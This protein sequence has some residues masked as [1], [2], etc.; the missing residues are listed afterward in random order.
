[1]GQRA[2]AVSDTPAPGPAAQ[3]K[4]RHASEQDT[5]HVQ[6]ARTAYPSVSQPL[7]VARC[8]CLDAS[9]V[10]L[11]LTRLCGRAPRGARG[12]DAGPQHYGSNVTLSGAR[13]L[14][15]LEAVMT[16]EGATDGDVLRAYVEPGCGP[17][18]SRASGTPLRAEAPR[19]RTCPRIHLTARRVN[20]VGRESK[21]PCARPRLAVAKRSTMPSHT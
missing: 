16:V 1:V 12:V 2:D 8:K 5:S 18:L 14:H 4:A 13:S 11:A 3:K 15:G 6:P 17:T 20:R 9:G 7:A 21:R 10:K 19:C